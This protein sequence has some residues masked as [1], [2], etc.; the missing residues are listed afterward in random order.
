MGMLLTI[1]LLFSASP[2]MIQFTPV[3]TEAGIDFQH[4]NGASG[5]KYLVETMGVG[6]A[7][8]DY[9]NDG[10]L[11]VYLV[12]GA[13][14]PGSRVNDR[15]INRLYR[16]NGDGAFTDV[17]LLAGVGD[18]HYGM[19]CC[20]G[21]YDNDGDLE[22][23]VT[24]FGPNV[25]Y[26]NNGD[27]AF[28]DVTAFAG[29]GDDGFSTGCAF[30]D[31][32][33]DGF[34]D[35]FVANYVQLDLG[36]SPDC[37][38][39]GIPAYCRPEEFPPAPDVM[40]HNNGD[41]T[42]SDVTQQAG[43]TKPGRGLGVVWADVDDDGW[44][45]LYIANDRMANFL[46]HNNGDGGFTEIGEL[47]GVA[48]NEH[49]YAESGMGVDAGDYDNDGDLDLVVTNYQAETNTLYRNDGGNTFW[50][51]TAQ[52]RL[53]EPT[54]IP[55][56]WG[57]GFVDFDNDGLLDVFFANG[58]LHDNIE[59][60]EEV[61]GYAQ[62]NQLFRNMGNGRFVEISNSGGA[63]LQIK[64]SSRGA[65]F[66]DYDNDGDIDI[67]T[68][69]INEAPDLLRND[70]VHNNHWIGIRLIGVKSNRDGIGARVILTVDGKQLRREVKSGASYLSQSDLRMLVGLG[71][72][73]KVDMI[74]V[75]WPSGV[76]D[77]MHAIAA[78]EWLTIREGHG[79]IENRR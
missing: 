35:I 52:A 29:V 48:F 20:V 34:L 17:T 79:I 39:R 58:H 40:Y 1:F 8:F 30:A 5:R 13:P 67:L 37:S 7:F 65:S 25:L 75:H 33:N 18:A 49:A 64:K 54:L 2:E 42:F 51:V 36:N 26:R 59:A 63:G 10:Y 71:R 70:T 45:D 78:D 61:G 14:L 46:Y 76:V 41:G 24:N 4:Y 31:Y 16:N 6:A 55:L 19:G 73:P 68:T 38:Q 47:A 23:Y 21:D 74:S 32:D 56:A 3:T 72:S 11:D 50:D 69:N 44:I 66:G 22:L 15:P 28:T 9:D 53:S 57:T 43:V 77:R 60:L 62:L 27:G 12:N